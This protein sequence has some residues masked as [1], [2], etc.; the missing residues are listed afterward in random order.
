MEKAVEDAKKILDYWTLMEIFKPNP[1]PNVKINN[2]ITD[3][4]DQS[5][6]AMYQEEGRK[7]TKPPY[8]KRIC[9]VLSFGVDVKGILTR[10]QQ[11]NYDYEIA[12][13]PLEICYGKISTDYIFS[14]LYEEL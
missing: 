3:A 8:K 14:R 2:G 12:D 11:L 7:K 4:E 10:D 9:D 1:F 5:D 6:Y 13:S